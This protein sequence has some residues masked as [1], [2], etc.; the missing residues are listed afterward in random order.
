ML[1]QD[2][3]VLYVLK[4]CTQRVGTMESLEYMSTFAATIDEE[5]DTPQQGWNLGREICV[6][7]LRPYV[8]GS[9]LYFY[10]LCW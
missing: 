5:G 6:L 3:A 1:T 7:D 8:H 2:S 10:S 4:R 9:L